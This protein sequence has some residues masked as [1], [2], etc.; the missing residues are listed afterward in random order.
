MSEKYIRQNKNSCNIVKNSKTYAKMANLEDAIFIRDFLIDNDWDLSK[1]PQILQKEDNY[2]VLTVYEDK[3]HLLSK[4]KVKPGEDTIA[5][6]IKKHKRNPNNSKYGLNIVKVFDV[7]VIKKQIAGDDYIFG[8]YD[9]LADAEFVRNFLM[10]NCWNV[11]KFK[12]IEFDEDTNTYKVVKVFDDKVYILDSFDDDKI[13]LDNVYEEFLAKISKNKHGLSHY[14]HLELLANH[15]EDLE[16]QFNVKTK[17]EN[18]NLEN[19]SE[20]PLND[21]IFNLTPFEQSVYDA[22][23][24]KATFEDIKKALIRYKSKNFE[25]KI[26]KN[27]DELIELDLIKKQDEF[28]IKIK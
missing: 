11:N 8:Y 25:S 20:D 13:D 21:I 7:F 22:I 5:K 24:D 23:G 18:W 16:S 19:I 1:T 26:N 28:Y 2:L 27:L 15:I 14:P 4:Y 3:I 9:N 6:L 12:D 10:D 17:D